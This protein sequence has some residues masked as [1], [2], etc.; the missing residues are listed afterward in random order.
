MRRKFVEAEPHYP[1]PC[2]EI[3][4]LIGQLY[5]VER[6]GPGVDPAA[7]EETR[8]AALALRARQREQSSALVEAIRDWAHQQRALPESSL[9]KA[10]A[11][12]LGLWPGLTRFLDDPR[13]PL[14]NNATERGLRAMVLG[15]KNHYGSRSK[16]GTEVAALFYSLI[17][18]AK[19]CGV[20]PK[21]YLLQ[22]TRAAL[23]NPGTVTLPHALLTA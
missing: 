22:A 4:D 11:Y 13:I 14:D 21:A 10:I 17:E 3:L 8:T 1:G 18:S 6:A 20:E 19:L 7:S 16:R 9:G 2:G 5:A 15:R 12:M 23:A